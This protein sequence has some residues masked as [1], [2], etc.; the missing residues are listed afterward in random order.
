M[1]RRLTD[2]ILYKDEKMKIFDR[3]KITG[4]Y[5]ITN[6]ATGETVIKKNVVV[7]GFFSAVISYL[8]GTTTAAIGI[9]KLAAG[10]GTNAAMKSDT[11]LQTQIAEKAIT[12]SSVSTTQY[13]CKI[14]L[15]PSEFVGRIRE[16]GIFAGST[17][18]SRVNVDVTKNAS[19]QYTVKYI[20]TIE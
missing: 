15:A 2:F 11:A 13:Q 1:I 16:L 20:L 12:S 4:T 17:L 5:Y 8:N 6:D 14:V 3:S 9:T 18:I 19:T 7:Q 10:T